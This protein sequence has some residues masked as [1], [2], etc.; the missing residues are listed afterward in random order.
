[1]AAPT[2]VFA[3]QALVSCIRILLKV[4]PAYDWV[5]CPG[6]TNC[7]CPEGFTG[8][9]GGAAPRCLKFSTANQFCDPKTLV[10]Q[11]S[12]FF[13]QKRITLSKW[14]VEK[15][16]RRGGE[17]SKKR[18]GKNREKKES[19]IIHKSVTG[20]GKKFKQMMMYRVTTS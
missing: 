18:E 17:K 20:E 6:S 11:V 1:M 16:W 5:I 12:K 4:D 2:I 3:Y 15:N 7:L 19:S 10:T 14:L 13:K 9:T 8:Q